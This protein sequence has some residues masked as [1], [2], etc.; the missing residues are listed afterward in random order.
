MSSQYQKE[1]VVCQEDHEEKRATVSYCT[2]CD[3][4]ICQECTDLHK[5]NK[6]LKKHQ[7]QSVNE[8]LKIRISGECY[9]VTCGSDGMLYAANCNTKEILVINVAGLILSMV[10]AMSMG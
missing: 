4:F 1:G 8:I 6:I 3:T 7:I 9:A 5:S 10:V 2:D